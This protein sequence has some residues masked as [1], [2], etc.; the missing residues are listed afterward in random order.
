MTRFLTALVWLP[1]LLAS[2]L[3]A[4]CETA[5]PADGSDGV[6][7]YPAQIITTSSGKLHGE[8]CANNAECK[9]G[10]CSKSTLQAAGSGAGVCV[11]QCN[12]GVGSQCSDDNSA[13]RSAEFTCIFAP[14]GGQKECARYCKTDAECQAWNPELPFCNNSGGVRFSTGV[15]V[16]NAAP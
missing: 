13:S 10:I 14:S 6:C 11:K 12:C 16:C 3:L 2:V 5:E 15:K 1:L 4:G 8:P 7:P 9:Y